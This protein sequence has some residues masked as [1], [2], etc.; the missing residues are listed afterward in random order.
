[1]SIAHGNFSTVRGAEIAVG[2]TACVAE[3]FAV[4]DDSV[5]INPLS[6]RSSFPRSLLRAGGLEPRCSVRAC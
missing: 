3:G 4:F 1:M 6:I 5:T 2:H